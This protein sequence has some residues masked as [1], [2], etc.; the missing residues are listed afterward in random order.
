MTH[1][2]NEYKIIIIIV[3]ICTVCN[4]LSICIHLQL[5]LFTF[6]QNNGA[7]HCTD[8]SNW[9][10]RLCECPCVCL[11]TKK[12]VRD[13]L[14]SEKQEAIA[15]TAREDHSRIGADESASSAQAAAAAATNSS[16]RSSSYS[17]P[18][19]PRTSSSLW[20][21]PACDVATS[22]TPSSAPAAQSALPSAQTQKDSI[23]QSSGSQQT[24]RFHLLFFLIFA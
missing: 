23:L 4:V 24:S 16:S 12:H 10:E 9:D 13:E 15:A 3:R 20:P 11:Q 17:Y 6:A 8:C 1:D 14:N 2:D 7:L 19:I 18:W 22:L 5:H 21:S